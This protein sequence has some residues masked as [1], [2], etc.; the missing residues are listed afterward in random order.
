MTETPLSTA[1]AVFLALSLLSAACSGGGA[2]IL[3]VSGAG[4]PGRS[5]TIQYGT[6]AEDD[7]SDIAVHSGGMIVAAGSTF[8]GFDGYRNADPNGRT[9]DL[10]VIAFDPSGARSRTIQLGTEYEDT[11]SDIAVDGNG[12]IYVAGSTAGDM[13]GNGNRDIRG[14]GRTSDL[15]VLKFG[16]DGTRKWIRQFGSPDDDRGRGIAVDDD[17]QMYVT[18]VTCGALAG[19]P[20]AGGTDL[21]VAKLDADG[22]LLWLNQA[23]SASNDNAAGIV[24]SSNVVTVVG[25]TFGQLDGERNHGRSD[26][27]LVQFDAGGARLRT[28][29]HGTGEF[30]FGVGIAADADGSLYAVGSTQGGMDGYENADPRGPGW[31]SDL[32]VAKFSADGTRQWTRQAGSGF[33]DFGVNIVPGPGGAVFVTGSTQGA[34]DGASGNRDP[35]GDGW[36]S[37]LFVLAFDAGGGLLWTR[38]AGTAFTDLGLGIGTGRDGAVYAAGK[39]YGDLDGNSNADRSNAS[40]DLFIIKYDAAGAKQ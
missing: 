32:F 17:G 5:W 6:V 40:A 35:R 19:T 21:F 33:S 8:G 15:I 16:A 37:D 39:T 18:G 2:A 7:I 11:A 3:P 4:T 25:T 10:F 24:I 20:N 38:Q 12:N 23:G 1:P 9:S 27:F 30:D 29:L 14:P 22:N 28:V 13:D 31:T 26:L 34:L 36:T